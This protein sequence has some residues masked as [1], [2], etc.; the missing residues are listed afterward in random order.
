MENAT[1]DEEKK[2]IQEEITNYEKNFSDS[3]GQKKMDAWKKLEAG[4]DKYLTM[5]ALTTYSPKIKEMIQNINESP[6]NVFIYS[7]FKTLE[8]INTIALAMSVNGYAKFN[9]VQN[10]KGEYIEHY[11][12][13]KDKNKPKYIIFE[14]SD[15]EKS[16][17][18]K[19]FNNKIDELPDSLQDSIK[20]NNPG[21]DN[22]RGDILKIM[23][24]TSSGAEG[25][26]LENIR[27]VHVTEPYW[28]DIRIQQVIGR[29]VRFKSHIN[30]PA[31]DRDVSVFI[32]MAVYAKGTKIDEGIKKKDGESTTDESIYKMA[33]NK[34]S[35][36]KEFLNLMK[37]SSVD[38]NLNAVQNS[39]EYINCFA[40]PSESV[41]DT[42]KESYGFNPDIKQDNDYAYI[43]K[44][45]VE[46]TRSGKKI[47]YRASSDEYPKVYILVDTPEK[48]LVYDQESWI[49]S[50]GK[51]R[52]AILVG[53]VVK[54]EGKQTI[55][56]L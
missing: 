42:G 20:K 55:K 32:Y 8:G 38:C 48:A 39:D 47:L 28:N 43:Q 50:D 46:T 24:S 19:I 9:L 6:G 44:Q 4:K 14:G 15:I 2:L 37:E 35:L 51:G 7:Q 49:G 54:K 45:Q 1:T 33:I 12:D 29:A 23:L 36:T 10:E 17:L 18:L 56:F 41:I 5:D 31:K 30:L 16:L 26:H 21:K 34:A 40:Y 3:D 53:E 25:I 52:R 13:T 11:P 22:L 27:Q